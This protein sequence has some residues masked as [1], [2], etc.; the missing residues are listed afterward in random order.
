MQQQQSNPKRKMN[1]LGVDSYVLI[2]AI[3]NW[4]AAVM[5]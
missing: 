2:A 1:A 3:L 4:I 5:L